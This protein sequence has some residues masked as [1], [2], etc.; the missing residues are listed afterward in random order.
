MNWMCLSHFEFSS[1]SA[2]L[3][4]ISLKDLPGCDS[5][6]AEP[7]RTIF[8]EAT[9]PCQPEIHSILIGI[10]IWTTMATAALLHPIE[11]HIG[12]FGMFSTNLNNRPG[13]RSIR[14]ISSN[15]C[16]LIPRH[17]LLFVAA[18]I[19]CDNPASFSCI[20]D[21]FPRDISREQR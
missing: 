3:R 6:F 7:R 21:Y 5:N 18:A 4:L 8:T 17:P 16:H 15:V 14:S 12:D 11:L 13:G 10:C 19:P 1:P 20:L 9:F 2:F